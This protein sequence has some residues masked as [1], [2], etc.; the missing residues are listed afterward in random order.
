MTPDRYPHHVSF[1]PRTRLVAGVLLALAACL[2]ILPKR[3]YSLVDPDESRYAEISR[4]MLA[5][6]DFVVPT[7]FGKAYLDKPPLYYWLTAASFRM[8]GV[9]ESSARLVPAVA[10]LLTI[11][12]VCVLGGRMVGPTAAWL[13]AMAML[14]CLGFLISA[15]F[16]FLDTL[17]T[18][19]TTVALLCGYL[20]CRESSLNR[21]WWTGSALACALG[22][23]AK[24]PIA[25]V[26]CVPPLVA[27]DWLH[28]ARVI[29][30]RDWILFTASVVAVSAPWFVMVNA[31]QPGFL[32]DFFWTH[33]FHRF[34]SGLSH[35]EP[36]WYYI[37]VLLASTFPCS[38]LLPAVVAF[39]VDRSESARAWRT[40]S[41]GF[42]AIVVAWTLLLFSCSSCKLAP[43]L[44]P[45]IPALCL[46]VGRTLEAILWG[47]LDN[48]F[49]AFVRRRSPHHLIVILLGAVLICGSIDV[50]ALDG[51]GSGRFS[52]WMALTICGTLA[53][54][55]SQLG[56]LA[57][58]LRAWSVVA[59]LTIGDLGMG[60]LE[61]YPGIATTRSKVSPVL[62]LCESQIERSASVVCFSLSYQADSLAFHLGEN[63]LHAYELDEVD[64]VVEALNRSPETI[65]LTKHNAVDNLRTRLPGGMTI[66]KL[67]QCEDIF[68]GVCRSAEPLLTA[69]SAAAY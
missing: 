30:L 17:L 38:L 6:G 61:F 18:L 32:A 60:V 25:F 69:N 57:R 1:G 55:A 20:A 59:L 66:K 58:S 42:L 24:G 45:A 64:H 21:W 14:S 26:L 46:L 52:Y 10:A 9:S 11:L 8:F 16:I 13:G 3:S 50:Y 47:R 63:A 39:L 22:V 12:A 34:V 43:Y 28:G 44:L 53:A 37:P 36:W 51:T 31:R 41:I 67:G 2:L 15:R 35:K 4:E 65:I 56:F 7:R 23:L 54:L 68:V 27:T 33:H 48:Q 29:R 49:L 19:C 5:S 40:R 62:H